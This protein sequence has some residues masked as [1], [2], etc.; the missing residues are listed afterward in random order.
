MSQAWSIA[1]WPD[2][3]LILAVAPFIGSF[4]GVLIQR[5]PEGRPVGLVRSS[6]EHCG[7]ALQAR[8]MVP[9][10]SYLWQRG[11]CRHCGMAIDRF[12]PAVEM[13]AVGIA[14]WAILADPDPG[15]LWADCLL[16]WTLLTLGWIDW[17]WM[18][19]P[20]VLTLP[21][22]LAGLLLTWWLEPWSLG[23]HAAGAACGYLALRG[24]AW[25][26]R[27][28]R[29]REGI[30]AG[31]AKLL[32]AAGAW[33]GLAALPVVVLL[34]ALLGLATAGVLALTGRRLHASTALPFGPCLAAATWL[35][36]LYGAGMANIGV[37][38]WSD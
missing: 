11:K 23:G 26:Y 3:W 34:A 15:R 14:L 17:R 21:L 13:A 30:G 10:L 29:G 16:G 32:A 6:C 35:V 12:H 36:W 20:D 31:D 27:A 7:V 28:V 37:L 1:G 38:P 24:V 5:L 19:L 9:L 22:L 33:L 2:W 8:D 25:C 4:A 18:L